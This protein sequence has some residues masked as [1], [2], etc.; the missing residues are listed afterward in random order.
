MDMVISGSGSIP[1]G[2]YEKITVSG[3]GKSEGLIRCKDF[4][5][6][7]SFSGHSD[8]E[9]E[10]EISVSGSLK[11]TGTLTTKELKASGS[12]KN[13]GDVTAA[14]VEVSGSFK[15][16]GNFY[17]EEK[18]RVS[19]GLRVEGSLKA[20][21]LKVYGGLKAKGD[22][23]AEK[24]FLAGGLTCD[25]LVNAEDV[26]IDIS[27]YKGSRVGSIGGSKITVEAN[28]SKSF[29][30]RL[31]DKTTSYL[32]VADSVEGDE[33]SLEYTIAETVTG[34]NVKIGKG[35]MIGVVYYSET[36]ETS[37]DAKIGRCEKI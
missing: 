31:F 25:G 15:T 24:A 13:D 30:V 9:C 4:R 3:S 6:S 19:G 16:E 11:N 18:I 10:G 28:N 37:P 35:C 26:Y 2:E 1:S 5:C 7:G 33:I 21:E 8:I 34:K 12:V 23:E 36:I 27:N 14:K 29:I 32:E 17:S 20:T 22:V